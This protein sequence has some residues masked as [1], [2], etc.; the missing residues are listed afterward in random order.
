MSSR[1]FFKIGAD[2][3]LVSP[4]AAAT[5]STPLPPS[6]EE[7][8]RRKCIDLKKRMS[9]VEDSN[10]AFR[11]RKVRLNR[12]IRKMRLERAYLLEMLGK[13]MKKNGASYDGLAA[14][15]DEESEGSSEGPP[16][17][18]APSSHYHQHHYRSSLRYRCDHPTFAHLTLV[19]RSHTIALFVPSEGIGGP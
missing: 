19:F 17:V 2:V 1:Q 13:R 10:D 11:Q 6:V 9:E 5:A 7:A 4:V 3:S 16:T 12:G 8:Y 14:V 18:S 15:Y